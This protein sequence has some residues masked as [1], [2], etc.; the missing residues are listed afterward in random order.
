MTCVP[1]TVQGNLFTYRDIDLFPA[2]VVSSIATIP[3]MWHVD[4]ILILWPIFFVAATQET[5][6]Q[7]LRDLKKSVGWVAERAVDAAVTVRIARPVKG[8]STFDG[9]RS[10]PGRSDQ[11][12]EPP[13]W[14]TTLPP[15]QSQRQQVRSFGVV[16]SDV[17]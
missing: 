4:L 15:H 8:A 3:S 5:P 14:E 17:S 6:H 16:Y 2:C 9:L 10:N 7:Q 12:D 1:C 13:H 11:T